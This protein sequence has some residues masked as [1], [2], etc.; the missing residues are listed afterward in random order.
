MMQTTASSM[1][2]HIRAVEDLRGP[3]GRLEALLNTGREDAPYTAMI[4]HPHPA[5]GGTMHNKVVYHTMKAF[6][7]FGL[8]VLRFNFR[9]VGLSEGVFDHGEGEQ[10]DAR[11]ALS[12]LEH[13]FKKP[14]LFAGFSFGS[15]VGLRACCGDVRVKGLIGL[16]LP[17]HAEGRD[18]TYGFLP[19]CIEPKLF[20]SGDHDQYGPREAMERVLTMAP[21]PKRTVWVEGAD[22]FFQGTKDSPGP[23]LDVMQQEIRSWLQSKF[24]LDLV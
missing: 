10:N 5:G 11:A 24:E 12:W 8:P 21:E 14:I 15:Y 13:N 22:H 23:K 1:N 4:C 2:T 20:I 19:K 6:A 17:V 16:G 7:S 9:G 3:A 18:Y